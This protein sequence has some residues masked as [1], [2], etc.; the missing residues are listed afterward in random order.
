MIANTIIK[1]KGKIADIDGAVDEKNV[2]MDSF[3]WFSSLS[4]TNKI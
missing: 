1:R 2:S 3:Q 4:P